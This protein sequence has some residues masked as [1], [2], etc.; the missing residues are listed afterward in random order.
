MSN[1]YWSIYKNLESEVQ[2][3][4]YS[5]HINDNLLNVYSSNISDII[6]RAAAEIESISKELYSH[7]G[8]TKTDHIKFDYDALEHLNNLWK[9]D[10]KIVMLSHFNCFIT[11]KEI[12]PFEKNETSS[13]NGKMT[14]SWNN[15]YQ[16]LKH[17]R[18]S[19]IH[20]G[21]IKY[22]FDIIAALFVLNLYYKDEFFCYSNESNTTNF[23]V[24]L[25]SDIFSIK[26]HKYLGYRD[27]SEYIKNDDFDECVYLIKATNES[28]E[29]FNE[30]RKKL[31]IRLNELFSKHQN[32]IQFI[33]EKN[34]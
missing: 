31:N 18:A 29:K 32:F 13:L 14:F 15:S 9:I 20:F 23:A 30:E 2:K 21:N 6:L 33:N 25:G 10:Q 26:L 3:L 34:I 19:S 5:I 27:E 17:N 28:L 24:N 7:N 12:K 1:I 8:G 11:N 16:N 22:M 4:S